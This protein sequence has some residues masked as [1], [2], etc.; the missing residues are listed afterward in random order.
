[1]I[2]VQEA[3]QRLLQNIHPT[4]KEVISIDQ[5]TGRVL[6]DDVTSKVNK[7]PFNTSAMDGY[8]VQHKDTKNSPVTLKIVETLP[9]GEVSQRK[10]NP[11]EAARV[12]TGSQIPKGAD[13]VVI[14]ENCSNLDLEK[15]EITIN[16]PVSLDQNIRKKGIDFKTGDKKLKAG[17]TLSPRDVALLAAMNITWVNVYKKPTIAILVTGSELALPGD[18]V[19]PGQIFSSNNFGLKAQIEKWGCI[20]IDLGIVSDDEVKIAEKIS[21]VKSVDMIVISGGMSVG[22]HDLVKSS[23]TKVGLSLDF[24]KVAMQPG[25][26]LMFG[27][28]NKIP[29]LG[30]PGNPVSSFVCTMLFLRSAIQTMLNLDIIIPHLTALISDDMPPNK[31]REQYVRATLSSDRNGNLIAVP[32]INQD[33][34][35]LSILAECDCL[36]VREPN[37]PALQKN[38]KVKIVLISH[39]D[40]LEKNQ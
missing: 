14:Q 21:K 1:M 25:K 23:L 31:N 35:L 22:D 5:A 15:E 11:G 28:I 39:L 30:L 3:R 6:A 16:I 18:E 33:S 2:S 26:P 8:A 20:A 36:I 9:A 34:S 38:D 13:A 19:H 40:V 32:F 4:E 27:E 10:L 29:L 37:A 17:H 7:P 12:F 24:W